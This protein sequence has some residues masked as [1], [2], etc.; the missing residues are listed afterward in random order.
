MVNFIALFEVKYMCDIICVYSI[1]FTFTASHEEHHLNSYILL[2]RPQCRYSHRLGRDIDWY[3]VPVN[4]VVFLV[5][6]LA[7][8]PV[9]CTSPRSTHP[10]QLLLPLSARCALSSPPFLSCR[11]V[12]A[13]RKRSRV[14]VRLVTFCAH[15]PEVWLVLD[16]PTS[17]CWSVTW[18]SF[19]C[20][21]HFFCLSVAFC[22]CV[23]SSS[24]LP[25]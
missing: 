20:S 15:N 6:L 7:P 21:P 16:H 25:L 9:S 2:W 4:V 11:S 18:T 24:T 17:L 23:F 8:C 19:C 1:W 13:I 3:C 12:S 10:T 14:V 22:W 5:A